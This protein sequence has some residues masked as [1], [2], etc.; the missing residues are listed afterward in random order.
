[1]SAKEFHICDCCHKIITKVEGGVSIKG[2]LYRSDSSDKRKELFGN[3]F[4]AIRGFAYKLEEIKESHICLDCL[5]DTL[6]IEPMI[7]S[8]YLDKSRSAHSRVA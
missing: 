8:N 2:N 7:L 4:P 1:M 6:E 5:F 3:N